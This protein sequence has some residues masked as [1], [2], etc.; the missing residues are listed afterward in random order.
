MGNDERSPPPARAGQERAQT[1]AF[2]GYSTSASAVRAGDFPSS[3]KA[4]KRIA[5]CVCRVWVRRF[6]QVSVRGCVFL[7]LLGVCFKA[8]KENRLYSAGARASQTLGP[9]HGLRPDWFPVG[10]TVYIIT[11]FQPLRCALTGCSPFG[12]RYTFDTGLG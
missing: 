10:Q 12:I 4:E 5:L 8:N 2:S 7:S 9:R 11:L 6:A 3:R 1:S